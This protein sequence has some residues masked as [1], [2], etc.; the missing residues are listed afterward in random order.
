MDDPARAAIRDPLR[1]QY[2]PNMDFAPTGGVL[3][4]LCTLGKC[5]LEHERNALAHHTLLVDGVDES[6]GRRFEQ[7]ALCESNHPKNHSGWT[8]SLRDTPRCEIS[9]ASRPASLPTTLAML[10]FTSLAEAR[11]RIDG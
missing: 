1:H 3:V 11:K 10:P 7:V 9:S 6:F 4:G 2:L 8:S 5:F